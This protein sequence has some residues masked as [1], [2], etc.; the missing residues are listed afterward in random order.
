MAQSISASQGN[1]VWIQF[2]NQSDLD[3]GGT[4]IGNVQLQLSIG[5]NSSLPNFKITVQVTAPITFVNGTTLAPQYVSLKHN[6]SIAEI[7]VFANAIKAPTNYIAL[8]YNEVTLIQSSSTPLIAPPYYSTFIRYDLKI[9]GGPQLVELQN[10]EYRCQLT[11]RLYDKNNQ[12]KSTSTAVYNFGKYFNGT[13]GGGSTPI[14]SLTLVNGAQNPSL[15]FNNGE[16]YNNGTAITINNGLRVQSAAPY[17]IKVNGSADNFSS[18][19][20][21]VIP[22]AAVKLMSSNGIPA[23]ID[24]THNTISLNKSTTTLL[25]K[26]SY[27]DPNPVYYNLKY[28]TTANENSFKNA[29]SGIYSTTLTFT[30]EPK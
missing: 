19:G 22:L 1:G 25:S 24:V 16:D 30:M 17:H 4:S 18:S 9:A 29:R 11:F 21:S 26:N 28:F 6:P 14:T 7:P 13:G 3:N 5:H 20:P 12:L 8:N 10:G 27:T 15:N 2:L 23:P